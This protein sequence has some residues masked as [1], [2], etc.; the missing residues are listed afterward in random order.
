MWPQLS[1]S[2]HYYLE[3]LEFA[4]REKFVSR[5]NPFELEVMNSQEAGVDL[6]GRRMLNDIGVPAMSTSHMVNRHRGSI[7]G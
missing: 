4:A 6:I 1:L 5:K 3:R 2:L 7:A